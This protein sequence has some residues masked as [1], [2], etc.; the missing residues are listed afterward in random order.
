[1]YILKRVADLWRH[2][3]ICFEVVFCCTFK[4]NCSINY[5]VYLS[6][7]NLTLVRCSWV[8]GV[9]LMLV[10]IV[11][12]YTVWTF[13][14]LWVF[15]GLYLT[16]VRPVIASAIHTCFNFTPKKLTKLWI[17]GMP[18][19][20]TFVTLHNVHTVRNS[21]WGKVYKKSIFILSYFA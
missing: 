1:M 20:L 3:G 17:F 2:Y 11:G 5:F 16:L 4:T 18:I 14:G 10:R 6:L 9:K 19:L 12:M 15:A 7:T 8:I 13:K 21:T